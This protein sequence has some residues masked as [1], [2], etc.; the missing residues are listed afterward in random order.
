LISKVV[1]VK[2]LE[3]KGMYVIIVIFMY[4]TL[5]VSVLPLTFEKNVRRRDYC[6]SM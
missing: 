5:Y 1:S 4:A 6:A 3:E 2:I